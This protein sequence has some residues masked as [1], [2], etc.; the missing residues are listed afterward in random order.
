GPCSEAAESQTAVATERY[1]LQVTISKGTHEELRRA[2][3]LLSH[4]VPNGDVDQ[5]LHRALELL[6]QQLEK[7]KFGAKTPQR[8]LRRASGRARQIPVHVRRAVWERDEKRC[9]FVSASGHRCN[10]THFLEFDHITPVAWGG[11]A[12]VGGIRLRC[13]THNQFEAEQ[14]FGAGFMAQ[15]R[16]EARMAAAMER[17]PA[18]EARAEASPRSQSNE[19]IEDVLAGLRSLGCRGEG[20]RRAAE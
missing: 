7:S 15:K 1:F 20:A 18:D 17:E 3:A 2:Q 12:T 11:V 19:R 5:V 14:V 4:S 8:V 9:T 16:E 6:N 13:R 10:A